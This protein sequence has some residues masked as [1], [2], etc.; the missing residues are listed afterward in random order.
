MHRSVDK[1][2]HIFLHELSFVFLPT[3]IPIVT[4]TNAEY[5]S[6][7]GSIVTLECNISSSP[8]LNMVYWQKIS[9][10]TVS[11][12]TSDSPGVYGSTVTNPS[13][14][15]QYVTTK[16]SGQYICYGQNIVGIGRSEPATL[17]ILGGIPIVTNTNAEYNS[18]FGSI[19]TLECNISSSPNLNMVYWQKISNETVSNITSDSPGVY[20]STVT[21]PSLTIQYVTTK[22][23]GQYICYGQNIVGIGRSEPATLTILGGIPIV[24]NTNAEYNSTF[25]SIVTLEC[26]ISSSPNLNMVYW[27]KISNETVSNITSDS[28]GVYGSTVTNPSLT[29]QYVTTKDSGQYICYGQN[30]VGIGRSEPATL[31][32]LEV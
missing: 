18:T 29:I 30:I 10:E 12:I 26:N 9:N 1:Q 19:V 22:D 5:N 15:I 8:N 23:S 14:T 25:G 11:N 17:T 24:T 28:P 31:T 2:C 27:Q 3:G 6:T 16:D 32:I 7:F 21:N 20:G 13:L 4:N